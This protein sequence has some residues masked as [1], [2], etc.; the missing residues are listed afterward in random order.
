[1]WRHLLLLSSVC[2][3]C[4][5]RLLGQSIT[6]DLQSLEVVPGVLVVVEG[7]TP[8][9]EAD[10]LSA[11]SVGADIEALLRSAGIRVLSE[12]EW[13]QLIG[14]PSLELRFQLLKPSRHLYLYSVTLELKQLT[15]LMRDS[16]KG[17]FAPTWSAD[18]LLGTKPTAMIGSLRGEI[19][20]MV[21]RF[22]D[23][24]RAAIARRG[25]PPPLEPPRRMVVVVE[26]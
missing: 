14:N 6:M 20:P 7:L 23:D 18:Q 5:G 2:I 3:L 11:D 15:V 13:Q 9:A 22:I 10:G 19:V 26:A 4:S 21:R 12:P 25:G 1:M 17:A 16:T 8:D 24:Y